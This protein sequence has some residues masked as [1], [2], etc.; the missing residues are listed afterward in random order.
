MTTGG[1]DVDLDRLADFVGGA[2]D[3]TP[4]AADIRHLVETDARWAEAYSALVAADATVRRELRALGAEAPAIPDELLARLD[5]ALADAAAASLTD[6][7][8]LPFP[9]APDERAQQRQRSQRRRRR[10]AVG[11]ATAAAVL[12]CGSVGVVVVQ[13]G[14]QTN[15]NASTSA[16]SAPDR[17]QRGTPPSQ[18]QFSGSAPGPAAVVTSGRDY[19]PD[20]L[21]LAA[22]NVPP[23]AEQGDAGSTAKN[24]IP[25]PN[26]ADVGGPLRRLADPP[27]LAT[28]LNAIVREYGGQVVVVDYARFQ[29]APAL[30]VVVTG[31][32][33]APGKRLVIVVGPTCGEGN[34]IADERYRTTL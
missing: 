9:A 16:G 14:R 15:E 32:R 10:W 5:A 20:T 6:A 30:I 28:C 33:T 17:D 13:Q 27:T 26:A 8:V 29:G 24:T 21:G 3:G 18:S 4:D 19:S 11:L 23:G 1:T 31:T 12:A 25:N 34:A 7:R 22:Q 2:L